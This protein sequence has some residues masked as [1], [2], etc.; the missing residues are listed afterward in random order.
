MHARATTNL[1]KQ[2]LL[3]T[4]WITLL[5]DFVARSSNLYKPLYVNSG[6][7][8]SRLS[9]SLFGLLSSSLGSA[10]DIKNLLVTL[11]KYDKHCNSDG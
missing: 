5:C 3:A 9:R 1:E 4:V 11:A 6:L 10:F 2:A 7:L 8:R